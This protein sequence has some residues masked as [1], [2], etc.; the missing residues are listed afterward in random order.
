MNRKITSLWEK[1]KVVLRHTPW[2]HRA[3]QALLG[4]MRFPSDGTIRNLFKGFTEAMV[5]Q[6]YGPL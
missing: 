2:A 6:M 3:L 1:K 5:V 4:M